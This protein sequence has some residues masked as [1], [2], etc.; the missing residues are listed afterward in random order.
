MVDKGRLLVLQSWRGGRGSKTGDESKQQIPVHSQFELQY[1]FVGKPGCVMM[2]NPFSCAQCSSTY[3]PPTK[4]ESVGIKG[5][6]TNLRAFHRMPEELRAEISNQVC[7]FS[8]LYLRSLVASFFPQ[9]A[10]VFRR[11]Y[12]YFLLEKDPTL[13]FLGWVSRRPLDLLQ[14]GLQIRGIGV[15]LTYH[16]LT[17]ITNTTPQH[18]DLWSEIYGSK[19]WIFPWICSLSVSSSSTN[20][21]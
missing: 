9:A 7:P 1:L 4:G 2:R 20:I 10:G 16:H 8:F 3:A 11:P 6:L 19:Q 14:N 5:Q 18:W 13:G 21:N 12:T 15:H 17:P